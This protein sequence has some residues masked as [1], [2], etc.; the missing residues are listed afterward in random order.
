MAFL[1]AVPERHLGVEMAWMIAGFTSLPGNERT[2][3]FVAMWRAGRSAFDAAVHQLAA[4]GGRIVPADRGTAVVATNGF[5]TFRPSDGDAAYFCKHAVP[6][7]L[8]SGWRVERARFEPKKALKVLL[9]VTGILLPL[10]AGGAALAVAVD[11]GFVIL[12][13]VFG[14]PLVV[15]WIATAR[16]LMTAKKDSATRGAG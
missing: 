9:I 6:A 4:H 13:L 11:P 12:S 16:V 8:L 3:D 14:L 1:P 5:V 2:Y 10:S 15:G 7:E